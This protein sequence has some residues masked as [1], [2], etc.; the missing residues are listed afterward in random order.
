MAG[1]LLPI[2]L[3]IHLPPGAACGHP[4]SVPVHNN[5]HARASDG[6]APLV[7]DHEDYHRKTTSCPYVEDPHRPID[8]SRAVAFA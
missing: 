3:L 4:N 2:L 1:N 8:Q 5:P 7:R 6:L